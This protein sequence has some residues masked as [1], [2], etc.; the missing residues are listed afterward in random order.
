MIFT[1]GV[2]KGMAACFCTDMQ[3]RWSTTRK[4]KTNVITIKRLQLTAGHT[5]YTVLLVTIQAHNI[6]MCQPDF[7]NLAYNLHTDGTANRVAG[8]QQGL[9]GQTYLW[10]PISMHVAIRNHQA[11]LLVHKGC[12]FVKAI[13]HAANACGR[14]NRTEAVEGSSVV[15][16]ELCVCVGL[17]ITA[18][19]T[20]N[21]CL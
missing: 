8:E 3:K 4:E 2:F 5:Q 13:Q 11:L 14:A 10:H 6:L 19:K 1:I 16:L 18:M 12:H 20:C 15:L 17:W 7:S 9:W 21:L